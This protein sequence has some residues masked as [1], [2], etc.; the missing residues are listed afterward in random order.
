[1]DCELHGAKSWLFCSQLFPQCWQAVGAYC[2][3]WTDKCRGQRVVVRGGPRI[4][5]VRWCNRA[6]SCEGPE[7]TQA[8]RSPGEG[9]PWRPCPQTS[10]LSEGMSFCS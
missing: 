4:L 8:T 3:F 6:C 7:L 9:A 1:M 10:L 2:Y 5:E